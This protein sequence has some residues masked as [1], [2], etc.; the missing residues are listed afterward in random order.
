M[1]NLRVKALER[2]IL[3]E[4]EGK[5]QKQKKILRFSRF[6]YL[7]SGSEKHHLLETEIKTSKFELL[8]KTKVEV[9]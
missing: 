6:N 8:Y 2:L 4:D 1:L 7:T 5:F 9:Q 3:D